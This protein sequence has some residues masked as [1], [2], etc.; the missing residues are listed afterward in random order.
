[1]PKQVRPSPG[2]FPTH[3]IA[4]QAEPPGPTG[5]EDQEKSPKVA[6]CEKA[7]GPES[8]VISSLLVGTSGNCGHRT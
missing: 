1:M 4:P 8:L 3:R 5:D 7:N 2:R 6:D